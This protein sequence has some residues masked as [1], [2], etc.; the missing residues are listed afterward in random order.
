[1]AG[2]SGS[3][4]LTT[5]R[6]RTPS[7]SDRGA[8][9]GFTLPGELCE[10]L[11]ALS[12]SNGATLYMTL[13][14]AFQ[15]LLHLYTGQDDIAVGSPIAQRDRPETEPLIGCLINTLVIRTDLSGDP[16][17][18]EL[19]ARV[20]ETTLGAYAHKDV[21]FE[22]L[23]EEL[24]PARRTNDT[25]FFQT[26]FVLQN[27]PFGHLELP[28]L[29]LS[30]FVLASEAAQFDLALSM[31]ETE[32]GLTGSVN[33]STDLF[34]AETIEELISRLRVLLETIAAH[35]ERRLLAIH[36]QPEGDA[37]LSTTPQ[38]DTAQSEDQFAF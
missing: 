13:L 22:L 14:A 12:R 29:T 28:G 21:P 31:R 6:P 25:P 20:R 7:R 2:L 19:L 1:M 37:R 17:F 24:Q 36:S 33:Y 15:T 16:S 11:R 9:L 35:P 3:L 30:P 32:S 38:H 4:E 10:E 18:T 26:W 5:D 27:A 8:W 34:D 23:V